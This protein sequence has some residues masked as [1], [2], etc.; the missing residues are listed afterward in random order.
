M[1]PFAIDVQGPFEAH[2]AVAARVAERAGGE[3]HWTGV[4][5]GR[6]LHVGLVE[7]PHR[8]AL[9]VVGETDAG[10][11]HPPALE[12]HGARDADDLL[13]VD[14]G[15]LLA[16]RGQAVAGL[17]L[18]VATDVEGAVLLAE[19]RFLAGDD[20]VPAFAVVDDDLHAVELGLPFLVG[21]LAFELD[22]KILALAL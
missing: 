14:I 18:D 10:P 22:A 9:L 4:A 19:E 7:D 12:R 11:A 5:F 2:V 3:G 8:V 21:G 13:G 16:E 1:L 20:V 17:E 15:R 6:E